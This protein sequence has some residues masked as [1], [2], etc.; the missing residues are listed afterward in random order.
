MISYTLCMAGNAG[1]LP[2]TNR[3]CFRQDP[4]LD[5]RYLWSHGHHDGTGHGWRWLQR[6]WLHSGWCDGSC[7][8]DGP[9][10]HRLLHQLVV[11]ASHH[12]R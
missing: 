9:L 12:R 2:L 8:H 5:W 11:I 7:G 3:S 6:W 4:V 1:K 10:R